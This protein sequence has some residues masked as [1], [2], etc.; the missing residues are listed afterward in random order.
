MNNTD[1]LEAKNDTSNIANTDDTDVANKISD[2]N[3]DITY[4]DRRFRDMMCKFQHDISI[5]DI[6]IL[7]K[8]KEKDKISMNSRMYLEIIAGRNGEYT[9]S[10]LADTLHLSRPSITQKLNELEKK[11]FIYKKQD[12]NDKR[13]HYLF[14]VKKDSPLVKEFEKSDLDVEEKMIE[15]FGTKEIDK[16]YDIL[17]FMGNYYKN[18]KY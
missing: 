2:L 1:N 3:K 15:K 17:E 5:N 8:H 12:E 11:G 18:M 4:P 9:A 13:I 6:Q 14:I 16:F 7:N 10:S